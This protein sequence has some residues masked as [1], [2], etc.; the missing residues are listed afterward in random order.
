[1]TD[2]YLPSSQISPLVADALAPEILEALRLSLHWRLQAEAHR[3]FD[4]DSFAQRTL[5]DNFTH[6]ATLALG[7]AAGLLQ[8]YALTHFG[9]PAPRALLRD[10]NDA[11]TEAARDPDTADAYLAALLPAHNPEQD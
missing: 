11:L 5:A 8:A 2:V 10:L 3:A 4:P 9:D 7:R 1:M 6:D